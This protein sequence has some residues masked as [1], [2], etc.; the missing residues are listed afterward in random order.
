MRELQNSWKNRFLTDISR[1]FESLEQYKPL[2]VKKDNWLAVNMNAHTERLE[3][4]TE[5]LKEFV[6]HG[7]ATGLIHLPKDRIIRKTSDFKNKE[8][9]TEFFCL[10]D[11]NNINPDTL[12][13]PRSYIKHNI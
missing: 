13:S 11:S 10:L 1:D 2:D 4:I 7:C 3:A 6:L 12:Y 5:W 8:I 9:L